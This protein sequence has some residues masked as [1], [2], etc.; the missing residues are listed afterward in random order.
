MYINLT[1]KGVVNAGGVQGR[2]GTAA[3]FV[4]FNTK[5]L[6]FARQFLVFNENFLVFNAT[7]NSFT[8]PPPESTSS[9]SFTQLRLGAS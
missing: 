9:P 8:H 3:K 2:D 6:V 4:I 1:G 5:F 7:F